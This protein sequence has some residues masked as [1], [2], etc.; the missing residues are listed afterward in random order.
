MK[1]INGGTEGDDEVR[2]KKMGK[3]NMKL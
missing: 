1:K 2:P 3:L